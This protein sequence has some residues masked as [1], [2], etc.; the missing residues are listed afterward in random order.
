MKVR[1]LVL[2]ATLLASAGLGVGCGDSNIEETKVPKLT[3]E[4][5]TPQVMPL[6]LPNPPNRMQSQIDIKFRNTGEADLEVTGVEWVAHPDRLVGIGEK[7]KDEACE[8]SADAAPTYDTS[9]TCSDGEYCWW[10][11]KRCREAGLPAPF[12]VEPNQLGLIEV[13]VLPGSES[14]D[15]PEAPSGRDVPDNYCGELLVKTNA[16]NNSDII[17]EGNLRIFFTYEPGSGTIDVD[18]TT[19]SFSGVAP[20]TSASRE[21]TITNSASEGALDIDQLS[22][23]EHTN[24]FEITGAESV[25][26][27]IA[28]GSQKTW[29]LTFNAPSDWDQETFGTNVQIL[30]SGTNEKE[31]LIPVT[32]SNQLDL[33][34]IKLEPN[35]L[36]FDQSTTQTLVISNEGAANLT[37]QSFSVQPSTLSS[38]YSFAISGQ[39]ID[40][41]I[42]SNEKV[43]QPGSSKEVTIDFTAPGDGNGIATLDIGYNYFVDGDSRNDSATATLLGSAGSSPVGLVS[44]DSF[45]FRAASGN[46]QTRSFAVRNV[47]T[48]DLTISSADFSAAT[49]SADD[50]SVQGATGTIPAGG[51]K[52]VTLS[53]DASDDQMDNVTLTLGSDT[54]G[55]PMTVLLFAEQG[56]QASDV[57]AQITPGFANDLTTVGEE[58]RF[59]AR[60]SSGVDQAALDGA[61]WVL[62]SR[63]SSSSAFVYKTG[64]DLSFFP[65]VAG[66]YKLGLTLY[67]GTVGSQ[68]TYTF[69]AE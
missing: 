61:S 60:Q 38:A 36:R 55:T 57:T 34:A 21:I 8:Y 37:L 13:I 46:S 48:Q 22:L 52:E 6:Q 40:N 54:A 23:Q 44:P 5:S 42:P 27:E 31:T 12:V 56:A 47:G 35:V 65:D 32:V 30:S 50:F 64:A 68:A 1:S 59:S 62:L 24:M 15:C 51:L 11:S 49:G 58:A 10:G 63:P 3:L 19:I 45:T 7:T 9:G 29:T 17:S 39:S 14:I 26:T 25:P 33:P 53:Y 16:N 43:I 20:G 67:D 2:A 66:E 18:P 4:Q 41:G 69:T 28:P